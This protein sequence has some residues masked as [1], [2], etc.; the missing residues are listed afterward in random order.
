MARLIY[1]LKYSTHTAYNFETRIALPVLFLSLVYCHIVSTSVRFFFA[2]VRLYSIYKMPL[3]IILNLFI[4][5]QQPLQGLLHKQFD[6]RASHRVFPRKWLH[7]LQT[8]FHKWP[9]SFQKGQ[10]K[11]SPQKKSRRVVNE[12]ITSFF[13]DLAWF[14][15]CERS[16]TVAHNQGIQFGLQQRVQQRSRAAQEGSSGMLVSSISR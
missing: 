6:L 15:R 11:K 5:S 1:I 2:N 7:S 9:H 8:S 16:R 4:C 12:L 3:I 14:R 13:T 10:W